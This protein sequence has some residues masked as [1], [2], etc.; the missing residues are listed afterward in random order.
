MKTKSALSY[1]GSDS[2]VAPFLASMLAHCRHITIPFVGGAA[3]IPHLTAKGIVANDLNDYAINFYQCLSGHYGNEIRDDLIKRCQHTLSHPTTIKQ[4]EADLQSLY[5]HRQAWAY[6]AICWVGRKG[7]GGTKAKP[8]LPS[9]RH[10]ADGGNNATRLRA[11]AD[12]LWAWARSFERCEWT[13]RDFRPLLAATADRRDCGI[14][15]DPP[16]IAAGKA[17]LHEFSDLDHLQLRE[18]LERFTET[19]IVIRYGDH[20]TIRDLYHDWAIEDAGSR[21]QS[22]KKTGEIWI[23]RRAL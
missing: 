18:A 9:I 8:G 22:N 10:T 1:F 13:A 14:Y 20:P 19:T 17:Y 5:P 16:W 15:L 6:W 7:K 4:A 12:D 23:S 2:E 11:A 21:T 3:I